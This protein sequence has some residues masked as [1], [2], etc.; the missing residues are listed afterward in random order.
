MFLTK[1]HFRDGVL[2]SIQ[3]EAQVG[4]NE[5]AIAALV[6]APIAMG[7]AMLV[8]YDEAMSIMT[9]TADARAALLNAR[10]AIIAPF[11]LK[12]FDNAPKTHELLELAEVVSDVGS[13][14]AAREH[15]FETAH[16][17]AK[18]VRVFMYGYFAIFFFLLFVLF[19]SCCA[20]VC[21]LSSVNECLYLCIILFFVCHMDVCMWVYAIG[22]FI[23]STPH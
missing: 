10:N 1:D 3:T 2:A 23:P 12:E 7:H 18:L 14:A 17:P 19:C 16:I 9:G 20:Y 5:D 22:G 11:E 8:V 4:N 21:F 15:H 13:L 6:C